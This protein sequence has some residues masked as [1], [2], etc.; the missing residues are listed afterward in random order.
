M[1]L[2]SE[3]RAVRR[4]RDQRLSELRPKRLHF[5][6]AERPKGQVEVGVAYKASLNRQCSVDTVRHQGGIEE[7]R[8][9]A[10]AP[11]N[12]SPNNWKTRVA[13][14]LQGELTRV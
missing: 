13:K 7:A 2:L 6:I 10:K 12:S 9:V 8:R 5:G 4:R 1:T 14:R 11:F 3:A